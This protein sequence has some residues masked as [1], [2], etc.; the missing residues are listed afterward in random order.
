LRSGFGATVQYTFSKSIDDAAA[1]GGPGASG[2]GTPTGQSGVA[3]AQNWLDLR[4]ERSLSNFDQRHLVSVQMQYSTGMGIAG[5]ALVGGWKGA[6]LK[7]WTVASTV[8]AGSGLPQTPIYLAPVQ[9]TGITGILRPSYTGAPLYA[10]LMVYSLIPQLTPHHRPA[11]GA[12]PDET[13]SLV[14]HSSC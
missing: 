10:L 3:V 5:S 13:L 8:S 12:T 1:L 9:G 4:A 11:N 14:P 6:L 2:I 7:Q